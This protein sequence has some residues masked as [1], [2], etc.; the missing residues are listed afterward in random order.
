MKETIRLSDEPL[1]LDAAIA[2]V[3][4]P[5]AGAIATFVGLVRDRTRG[6][7][8]VELEYEAFGPMALAQME[9]IAGECESRWPGAR[10]AIHHRVG[11]LRVG[12]T[13]VSIAAAA[14]HRAEAFA[15]CRHAI[16]RLKEEVAIW[17]R[18]RFEDGAEWVGLGP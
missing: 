18:E 1:S 12:E 9:S 7:R 4:G 15:A 8:V 3:R 5:G 2:S 17:K 16:E 10:V 11:L 14:P 13:A 6:R